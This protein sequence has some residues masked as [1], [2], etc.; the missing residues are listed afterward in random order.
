MARIVFGVLGLWLAAVAAHPQGQA[1][2]F[3]G[4][5]CDCGGKM[6]LLMESPIQSQQQPFQLQK[7][8]VYPHPHMDLQ[9]KSPTVS[10]FKYSFDFKPPQNEPN[11]LDNQKS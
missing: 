2:V 5:S 1:L 6:P 8:L 11:P 4:S 9:P 10:D 3:H 7:T